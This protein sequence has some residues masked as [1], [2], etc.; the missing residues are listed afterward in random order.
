MGTVGQLERRY[1]KNE[2]IMY[3]NIYDFGY[4]ADG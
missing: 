2:I 1:T 3:L 4:N